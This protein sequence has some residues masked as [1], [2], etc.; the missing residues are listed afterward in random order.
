MPPQKPNKQTAYFSESL[1]TL[2]V[3]PVLGSGFYCNEI[4]LCGRIVFAW[5]PALSG[6]QETDHGGTTKKLS[7]LIWVPHPPWLLRTTV[8]SREEAWHIRKVPEHHFPFQEEG[9]PSHVVLSFPSS[10][11]ITGRFKPQTFTVSM[12]KVPLKI[13]EFKSFNCRGKKACSTHVIISTHTQAVNG[14]SQRQEL[15]QAESSMSVIVFRRSLLRIRAAAGR[16]KY[17]WISVHEALLSMSVQSETYKHNSRNR[18]LWMTACQYVWG[19]NI[20]INYFL[21]DCTIVHTCCPLRAAENMVR[22]IT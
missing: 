17:T 4:C 22:A 12:M 11:W 9:R 13:Q 10:V 19:V 21:P 5:A 2:C 8:H 3:Y 15:R 7:C 20:Q 14:R 18:C 16:E 6:L 1:N